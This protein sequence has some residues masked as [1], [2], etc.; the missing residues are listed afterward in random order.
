MAVQEFFVNIDLKENQIKNV[1]VEVAASEPTTGGKAGQVKTYNGNFYISDGTNFHMLSREATVTAIGTRVTSLEGTVG[2]SGKGLV[3]DVADIKALIGMTGSESG[4]SLADRVGALETAVGDDEDAA[5]AEGSLYA[6]IAKNVADISANATA[7]AANTT[8]VGKA[9]SDA[10]AAGNKATAN[11]SAITALQGRMDTAENDIDA[12][13]T[14]VGTTSDSAN[15]TGSVYG[16]IAQNVSDISALKGRVDTAESDIDAL[17]TGKVDKVVGKQLSTEDYT[18]AEK[19]KLGGIAEGAQVNVIETVKVDGSPLAVESKAVNIDLSAYAKKA[20]LSS[21]Y[22]YKGSVDDTTGLPSGANTG[23]VYNINNQFTFNG[24]VYPAG[25]NVAWNGTA[26]DP[27]GGTVDLSVYYTKTETDGL[28]GGKQA[29][30]TETQLAAA[31]SGITAAK[32]GTYDGYAALITAAKDAADAAQETADKKVDAN[33]AITAGTKC[34]ISYDA[35]GLVTA[36]ADLTVSDLPDAIPFSKTTGVLPYAQSP[37]MAASFDV[38][39][40]TAD[41]PVSISTGMTT[42]L[43]AQVFDTNNKVVGCEISITGG[44]VA[45]TFSQAFTGTVHVIGLR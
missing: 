7:I 10:T 3:K 37:I 28:L 24:K 11:A 4:Q 9:Q 22:V 5:S 38:S 26:W 6:R 18:T 33:S 34:K 41:T 44:T 32:V 25:T 29:N 40:A 43:V 31:N 42:A 13:E 16:R 21:A 2:D 1:L 45:L 15:A 35:K 19:T 36:G 8:A 20:D 17:E 23:D 30:L 12:L 27:L 14:S 39:A